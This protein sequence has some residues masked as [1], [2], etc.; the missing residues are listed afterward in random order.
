MF[1]QSSSRRRVLL[2]VCPWVGVYPLAAEHH[3][4]QRRTWRTQRRRLL[5]KHQESLWRSSPLYIHAAFYW[6]NIKAK[7]GPHFIHMFP[8]CFHTRHLRIFIFTDETIR[9]RC[10]SH[11]GTAETTLPRHKA[12]A[13]DDVW[14]MALIPQHK[15]ELW[16]KSLEP[17]KTTSPF[18]RAARCSVSMATAALLFASFLPRFFSPAEKILA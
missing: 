1:E 2:P 5:W 11:C 10:F 17:L 18:D 16:Q 12:T 7:K 9:G 6:G 15:V 4:P 8:K 13:T 3:S 14:G